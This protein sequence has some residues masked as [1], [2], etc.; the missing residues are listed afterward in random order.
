MLSEN[1]DLPYTTHVMHRKF[2]KKMSIQCYHVC[3]KI[4]LETAAA[5]VVM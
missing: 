3:K 2:E 5:V 4:P 1:E